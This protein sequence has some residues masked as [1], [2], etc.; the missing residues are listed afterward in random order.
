MTDLKKLKQLIKLMVDN[1][2]TELNIE[3]ETDKI[4]LKRKVEGEV[5]GGGVV[6]GGGGVPMQNVTSGNVGG[7]A[8]VPAEVP[9]NPPAEVEK[10]EKLLEITSP[11]VGSFYTASSPDTKDFVVIGDAV[12]E[13]TVVCLVEAMKVY[14]EIKAEVKGTIVKRLVE[15]GQAVEFGQPL[16]LVKPN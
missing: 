6:Y 16:Y 10:E 8:M 7:G 9:M 14:N 4:R 5:I 12:N 13:S 1:D 15:N 2:L 3:N 11:M